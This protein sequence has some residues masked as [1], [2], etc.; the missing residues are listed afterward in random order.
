MKSLRAYFDGDLKPGRII[1]IL[2]EYFALAIYPRETLIIFDEIQECPRA[3]TS[4]KYFFTH[5]IKSE[6]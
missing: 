2:E 6:Y 3:L 4:L 5:K 1:A